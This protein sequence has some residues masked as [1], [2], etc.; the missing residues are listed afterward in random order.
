MAAHSHRVLVPIALFLAAGGAGCGAAAPEPV[1][2]G[3]A[4]R[5]SAPAG[6]FSLEEHLVA[7]SGR[8][9]ER[10]G[11]PAAHPLLPGEERLVEL[12]ESDAVRHAPALSRAARELARTT[13]DPRHVPGDLVDAVL[14]WA[15]LYE[16]RPR[17]TLLELG[18]PGHRCAEGVEASGSAGCLAVLQTIAQSVARWLPADDVRFGV[19]MVPVGPDRTR[20]IVAVS[21][22]AL[23][24]EPMPAWVR[25]GEA[26]DVRGRLE[27]G[28]RQPEVVVVGAGGAWRD[29]PV[30]PTPGGGFAASVRCDDDAGERLQVEVLAV[31]AHGPEVAAN[32]RVSCGA[33]PATTARILV[34]RLAPEAT[35]DDVVRAS[36][37]A[38][39]DERRRAGLAP[40]GWSAEAA[41][42]ARE[43]SEDMVRSGFVGHESPTT[44]SARDRFARARLAA[45]ALRENV[46]RGYGPHG[47][48]QGLLSSP[49]H[50]VNL[51]ADD[52]THAGIGAAWDEEPGVDPGARRPIVL[53]QNLFAVLGADAPDDPAAAL[54]DRVAARRRGAGL[55][56][57]E[58]NDELAVA[59]AALARGLAAGREGEARRRYDETLRSGPFRSVETRLV[60]GGSFESL[61][62][63]D[64]WGEAVR[65]PVGWGAARVERGSN[66]GALTLVVAVGER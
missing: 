7:L 65:G 46:A 6:V 26:I 35:L 64:L 60:V 43:H 33:A 57:L 54:R 8:P 13:P 2:G 49:G 44:G 66:A 10:Y 48:H 21:E 42:I 61:L 9:A 39:N 4:A 53:T 47:I 27:A 29:I 25:R 1:G 41:R 30:V 20:A 5:T 52:V 56:P 40:L 23:T 3:G 59:A 18:D 58:W 24:L 32:F 63:L 15:G 34:E 31:G 14:A 38:L 45:S 36:F 22:V 50:R 11:A 51:L 55:A 28:R 16:P 37:A 62:A 12:L 17:L 19:G